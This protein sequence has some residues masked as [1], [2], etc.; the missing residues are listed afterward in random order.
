MDGAS[1]AVGLFNGCLHA[2]RAIAQATEIGAES[3][4]WDIMMRIELT[5]FEVWGRA[6]KFLD[7]ETGKEKSEDG[8]SE[9]LEL[10]DILQI[11]AARN[12]VRDILVQLKATLDEFKKSAERYRVDPARKKGKEEQK[13]SKFEAQLKRT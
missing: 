10:A 6:L 1:A 13:I 5:R 12:L 7:E 2:Y 9:T 3:M 8:S 11:D 4:V